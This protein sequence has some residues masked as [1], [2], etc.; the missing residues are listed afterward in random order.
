MK[1]YKNLD[2][3][4][5]IEEGNL[6]IRRVPGHVA[7]IQ[8]GDSFIII[9]LVENKIYQRHYSDLAPESGTPFVSSAAAQA[10]IDA[11]LY[12]A[13]GG[14]G[15]SGSTTAIT[16]TNSLTFLNDE[17]YRGRAAALS[18]ALTI[19][20]TSAILG[21]KE[22]V[23]YNHTISPFPISGV[24]LIGDDN[25]QPSIDMDILFWHVGGSVYA[26]YITPKYISSNPIAVNI[27]ITGDFAVDGEVTINHDFFGGIE[28]STSFQLYESATALPGSWSAISGLNAQ[29]NTLLPAQET[30]YIRAGVTAVSDLPATGN[31][32]FSPAYGP[33]AAAPFSAA[34]VPGG[35]AFLHLHESDDLVAFTDDGGSPTR[36]LYALDDSPLTT[37]HFETNS[38]TNPELVREV[39]GVTKGE[40]VFVNTELS[41]LRVDPVYALPIVSTDPRTV[42]VRMYIPSSLGTGFMYL[43]YRDSGNYL[44][45]DNKRVGVYRGGVYIWSATLATGLVDD[46]WHNL[47]FR[48]DSTDGLSVHLDGVEIINDASHHFDFDL[49]AAIWGR[50]GSS[51]YALRG[52][53]RILDYW[54]NR[55]SDA[56]VA[57][58]NTWMDTF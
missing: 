14:G 5:V 55:I 23:R 26:Q 34:S 52:S 3:I 49:A 58:L 53:L 11:S 37:H 32:Q 38:V 25:F 7:Y 20:L 19:D 30:K 4:I 16:E 45:I 13:I 31:E 39:P 44:I 43:Q 48:S 8:Q 46:A 41:G 6:S 15:G 57:L 40:I 35:I 47:I 12:A 17:T 50:V 33:I 36:F 10:A 2:D 29:V 22:I 54:D 24:T 51:S 28:G 27:T 1:I 18:G 9:D 21:A 56:N 42:A